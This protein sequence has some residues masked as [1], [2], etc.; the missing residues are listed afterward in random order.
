MGFPVL[1]IE[2]QTKPRVYQVIEALVM[3]VL[4]PPEAGAGC[5]DGGTSSSSCL[6][7]G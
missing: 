1:V 2:L 5:E 3:A 7:T 4:L 6:I